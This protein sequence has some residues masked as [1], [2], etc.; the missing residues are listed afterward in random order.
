[1]YIGE[2]TMLISAATRLAPR[3]GRRRKMPIGTSGW[4]RR[5][6][7]ARNAPSRRHASGPSQRIRPDVQPVVGPLMRT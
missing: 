7:I 3:S 1:M 2:M 5:N 6:W 4:E